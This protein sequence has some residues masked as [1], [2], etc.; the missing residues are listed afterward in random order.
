MKKNELKKILKP[1]IK[2]CIKECIFE[3]GVLSGIITEVAKGIGTQRIVAESMVATK[4]TPDP[5]ELQKKADALEA[6]RQ[7]RIKKLNENMS[8][9][10][11]DVFEGTQ[12]IL[13]EGNQHSPLAGTAPDNAGVDIT[14][15]VNLAD[16]KWKHL[17]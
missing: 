16:G 2:E 7:E 11:V 6:Q 14:G 8:F 12:E 4:N 9:G 15:I 10:G 5:K 13:P 3:E 17:I 1:L